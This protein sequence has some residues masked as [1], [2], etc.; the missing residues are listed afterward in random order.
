MLSSALLVL[1]SA[2]LLLHSLAAAQLPQSIADV[3]IA[4]I[5]GCVDVHP[6]TVNC[7][8]A[9][10]TLRI[11][12]AAGFPASIDLYNH[13]L[14]VSV[15]LGD[16]LYFITTTAWP[17]TSDPTN[18]SVFVNV[19][20]GAYYPHITDQLIS[21]SI[22]DH[23]GG[24]LP[25]SSPPFDGFSYRFEGPPTLTSIGG[26]EG[27]GESTLNCL[28]DS[29]V[30]ELRGSGLLWY[31]TGRGVRL[32]IGGQTTQHALGNGAVQLLQV[33][34]DSYAVLPLEPL[35]S[36][37]LRR[38]HY[39]GVLLPLNLTSTALGFWNQG[40]FSYT[41][42]SLYI[43]FVPLP[44]PVIT[45]WYAIILHYSATVR[46]CHIH[47][48]AHQRTSRCVY[49]CC[50]TREVRG[51]NV[52]GSRDNATLRYISCQPAVAQLVLSGYYFVSAHRHSAPQLRS[53]LLCSHLPSAVR[54]LLL[55]VLV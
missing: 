29:A 16:Y 17:D 7:S 3:E 6:V 20:A 32:T 30:I 4:S 54:L 9:T 13:A 15:R 50:L 24:G 5:T 25:V 46:P 51:C 48:S 12:T 47:T 31:S 53:P 10:T 37:L 42:N 26:C 41:T 35:F 40:D 36:L 19:T 34:N 43:S 52:T 55:A 44:L 38:Q 22:L 27:S 11:Q 33:V 28:P 23:S 49:L 8:V 45:E 1:L 21:V 39:A 14:D 2:V 18:S